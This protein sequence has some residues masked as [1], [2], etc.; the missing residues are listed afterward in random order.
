MRKNYRSEGKYSRYE[1]HSAR[2]GWVVSGEE[3]LVHNKIIAWKVLIPYQR[4]PRSLN[5]E[6]KYGNESIGSVADWIIANAM[7]RRGRV[8][9]KPRI[10]GAF[11]EDQ[12]VC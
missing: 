12:G 6:S 11:R 1:I 4:F 5:L 3:A 2:T 7:L 10:T 9:R 8:L